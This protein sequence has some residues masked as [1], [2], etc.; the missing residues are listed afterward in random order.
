[1][2]SEWKTAAVSSDRVSELVQW[3]RQ[4]DF[5][6]KS[7]KNDQLGHVTELKELVKT[8]EMIPHL[9]L[10]LLLFDGGFTTNCNQRVSSKS[11]KSTIKPFFS[12]ESS[13]S[14]QEATLWYCGKGFW[15][16]QTF[17]GIFPTEAEPKANIH[18][19]SSSSASKCETKLQCACKP[20]LKTDLLCPCSTRASHQSWLRLLQPGNCSTSK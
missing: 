2:I 8:K 7:P 10:L 18:C 6:P 1:M 9:I 4:V 15:V 20:E 13:W 17:S 11:S 12:P 14:D 19:P 16:Q 5:W 3:W